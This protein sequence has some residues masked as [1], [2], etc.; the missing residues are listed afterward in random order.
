MTPSLS[1]N[2]STDT[3]KLY[4]EPYFLL[5]QEFRELKTY[6]AILNAIAVGNT[7]PGAIAQFCGMDARHLYPYLEA[8]TR[9][10]IIEREYPSSPIGGGDYTGSGTA[11]LT[12]GITS[13]FRIGR[14]SRWRTLWSVPST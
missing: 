9:L 1:G 2:S 7:A 5:S 11:S 3:G 4:R 6:Q 14:R 13:S 8:M 12:S 10:E